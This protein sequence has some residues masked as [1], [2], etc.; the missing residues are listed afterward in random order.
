MRKWL[1]GWP[2]VFLLVGLALVLLLTARL[3]T[4]EL[5]Q[6]ITRRTAPAAGTAALQYPRRGLSFLQRGRPLQAAGN[7]PACETVPSP[8]AQ[9]ISVIV[10]TYVDDVPRLRMYVPPGYVPTRS[11]LMTMPL[12]TAGARNAL[13]GEWTYLQESE[14]APRLTVWVQP[15]E[16][17][18][19]PA[20]GAQPGTKQVALEECVDA[21]GDTRVATFSLQLPTGAAEHY[22]SAYRD[23]TDR[24]ILQML[25]RAFT[26]SDQQL[27]VRAIRSVTLDR[28]AAPAAPL[29]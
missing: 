28:S 21:A 12:D 25:G 18:G 20:V 19:Y 11:I 26:E 27:H 24:L 8:V 6:W 7:A 10:E 14:T 5:L 16:L 2:G 29:R 15:R 13:V 17:E 1:S 9:F 3:G 22:V 23:L 4:D